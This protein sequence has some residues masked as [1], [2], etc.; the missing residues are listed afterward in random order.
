M[1]PT[2]PLLHEIFIKA[3]K[4]IYSSPDGIKSSPF[5]DNTAC[6]LIDASSLNPDYLN[7][8]PNPH[9]VKFNSNAMSIS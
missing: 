3:K 2:L 9:A 7:P 6:S 4:Y 5:D 8:N 1:H